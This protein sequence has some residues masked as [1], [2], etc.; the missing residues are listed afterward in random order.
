M[1]DSVT[2]KKFHSLQFLSSQT[3]QWFKFCEPTLLK[4]YLYYFST[5]QW[6]SLHNFHKI[7]ITVKIKPKMNFSRPMSS[8]H[9]TYLDVFLLLSEH[10][11]EKGRYRLQLL[12][13][14][15]PSTFQLQCVV[16]KNHIIWNWK[17]VYF[18]FYHKS[19]KIE[20]IAKSISK[21]HTMLIYLTYVNQ[22][23]IVIYTYKSGA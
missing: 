14:C 18:P 5:L 10:I 21:T 16:V 9:C 12:I 19:M 11:A 17:I 13:L 23:L 3:S 20:Y 6:F 15:F 1:K 22:K 7:A 2:V 4:S 8:G